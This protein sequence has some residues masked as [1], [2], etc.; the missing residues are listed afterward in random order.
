[1]GRPLRLK[2]PN[3]TYHI[4]SR[5]N[6]K[7]LFI[8]KSKDRKALCRILQRIKLKYSARIYGFTPMGN[9]FHLI[10]KM[11]ENT[12]VSSFMCEFK[13]A[14]AKYY[15]TKYTV[16][17]HFWGDRFRSTIIE[18][19]KHILACLRYI[20]RNPVNAGLVDYPG[21]YSYSSYIC[22]AYGRKHETVSIDLHPTYLE[23][24]GNEKARQQLYREYVEEA[25]EM[26]DNLHGRLEKFR[27]FGSAVFE[28]KLM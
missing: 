4:T 23:L 27:I 7:Q 2:A 18:E 11:E 26:S 1:M 24:S 15:N 28:A 17:G 16:S 22:Y 10:I 9:H 20:D 19:N 21:K 8:K 25:D 12:D 13:T 14:Y 5:T 3:L 6:G